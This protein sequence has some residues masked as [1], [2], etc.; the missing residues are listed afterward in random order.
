MELVL[1]GGD[2]AKVA[3]SAAQAPEQV[4]VLGGTHGQHL[5]I[6]SDQISGQEVVA[7]EAVLARQPAEAAAKGEATNARIGDNAPSRGQAEGL[8]L[9]I[10]VPPG[11][12]PL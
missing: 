6:G 11:G 4:G 8:R 2:H 5:A 12:P 9:A 10:E 3:A 7:G 1:E